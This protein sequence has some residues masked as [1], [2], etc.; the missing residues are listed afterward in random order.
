MNKTWETRVQAA[1]CAAET[2]ASGGVFVAPSALGGN[3][4]F[5]GRNFAKGEVVVEYE[6]VATTRDR[7]RSSRDRDADHTHVARCGLWRPWTTDGQPL[8]RPFAE[9]RAPLTAT[10]AERIRVRITRG[11][12][13]RPSAQWASLATA[14]LGAMANSC[15]DTGLPCTAK[16]EWLRAAANA[17][18]L[19]FRGFLVARADLAR[20]DE[21]LW[22]YPW[23]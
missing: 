2:L 23:L 16:M 12:E 11:V 17:D 6:G 14:G 8:A 7:R 21:I 15:K 20:G 9:A 10:S 4:L 5:A 1:A 18:A 13:G 19:P 3:G 22:R